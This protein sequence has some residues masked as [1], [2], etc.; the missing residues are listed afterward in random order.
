MQPAESI[1]TI[2]GAA[3]PL[4]VKVF[5]GLILCSLLYW[6]FSVTGSGAFA[7]VSSTASLVFWAAFAAVGY[8]YYW[9][10]VS[11]TRIDG[12]VISQTWYV[13]KSVNIPDITHI[14]FIVIPHLEWLIAPRLVV[15]V[16]SRGSYVFHAADSR[17]LGAFARISLG[18]QAP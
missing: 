17:L 8:I 11:R 10:L 1:S 6:F 9:I 14:K 7:G 18:E 2:D 4:L 3:F 16:R 12:S 5:G 15:R 13:R